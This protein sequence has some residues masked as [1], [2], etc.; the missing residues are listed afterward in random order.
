MGTRRKASMK[1]VIRFVKL[2]K[3]PDSPIGQREGF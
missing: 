2:K 1:A 3:Q